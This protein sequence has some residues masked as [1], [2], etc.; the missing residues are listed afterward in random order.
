MLS[1]NTNKA[2]HLKAERE[3]FHWSTFSTRSCTSCEQA[4]NGA[5]ST[6]KNAPGRQFIII[7]RFGAKPIF[8]KMRTLSCSTSTRKSSP[9]QNILS[10]TLVT[11]KMFMEL[12]V[13][14]GLLLIEEGSRPKHQ[15]LS[16]KQ[17]YHCNL[18]FIQATR[19]IV[20][21]SVIF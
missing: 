16:T 19:M 7:F 2:L 8:S 17:G 5:I 6:Q 11:L 4:L 9:F 15:L 20:R 18:F 12:T 10:W 21:L 3:K 13:L 14:V 1:A